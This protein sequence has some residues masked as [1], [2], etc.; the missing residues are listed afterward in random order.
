MTISLISDEL[1][2]AATPKKELLERMDRI[3]PWSRWTEL[4]QPYYYKGEHGNKPYPLERMLRIYVIQNLY[5]HTRPAVH[6][7]SPDDNRHKQRHTE[8]QRHD[9]ADH[10]QHRAGLQEGAH[11]MHPMHQH[12]DS[13]RQK[14]YIDLFR[15]L[16][17]NTY[18]NR[19]RL[20]WMRFR[21]DSALSGLQPKPNPRTSENRSSKLDIEWNI[22]KF[23]IEQEGNFLY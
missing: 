16:A 1:R 3:I 18:S 14:S 7:R 2:Q 23:V 5:K 17:Y 22:T 4:V 6:R 13:Q 20:Q 12:Q 15:C 11:P 21:M 10:R 9:S 19:V 8:G